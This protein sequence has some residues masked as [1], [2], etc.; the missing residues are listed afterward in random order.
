MSTTDEWVAWERAL[1]QRHDEYRRDRKALI[2][3]QH[4][5]VRVLGKVTNGRFLAAFSSQGPP[6]FAGFISTRVGAERHRGVVFD[7]KYQN[8][9]EKFYFKNLPRHQAVDLEAAVE[10]GGF[11]FLCVRTPLSAFVLDWRKVGDRYWSKED[12]FAFLSKSGEP[13]NREGDWLAN[14]RW[15]S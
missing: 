4:P 15:W 3:R 6:D 9:L 1:I 14:V 11:G 7:A 5:T 8:N 10:N 12:S 13:M 2:F